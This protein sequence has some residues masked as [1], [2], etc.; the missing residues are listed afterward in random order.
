[1]SF[2]SAFTHS[3]EER[4][5]RLWPEQE[6][7]ALGRVLYEV[8]NADGKFTPLERKDF[9]GFLSRLSSTASEVQALDLGESV[10][11]LQK[12]PKHRKVAYIWIAHALFAD[13]AYNAVEKSFVDGIIKKYGF[14]EAMLRAEIKE[15]QKQK[16]DEGLKTILAELGD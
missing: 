11:L 15:T 14:D 16:V 2:L 3:V 7:A 5:V 10:T 9:D 4:L 8:Y 12:D 1:M 6:R 13:G